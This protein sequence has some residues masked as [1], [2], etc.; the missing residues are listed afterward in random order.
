LRSFA[1]SEN[2]SPIGGVATVPPDNSLYSDA[3]L[4]TIRSASPHD[5]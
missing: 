2:I 1:I 4:T 5:E 3:T